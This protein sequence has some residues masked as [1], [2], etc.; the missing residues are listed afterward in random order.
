MLHLDKVTQSLT[1][2][3]ISP[4]VVAEK[5]R[6]LTG[7]QSASQS[8]KFVSSSFWFPLKMVH[9]KSWRMKECTWLAQ[10]G[11]SWNLTKFVDLIHSY[12]WKVFVE[13]GVGYTTW[14]LADLPT[15]QYKLIC[16]LPTKTRRVNLPVQTVLSLTRYKQVY[17]PSSMSKPVNFT[18]HA[19]LSIRQYKQVY[20]YLSISRPANRLVYAG[21]STFQNKQTCQSSSLSGPNKPSKVRLPTNQILA[22]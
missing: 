13:N 2:V 16:L 6:W 19:T 9:K 1:T 14:K 4:A 22:S 17:Q 10:D 12:Y 3:G 20:Q 8:S 21:R 18:A 15:L 5:K 11:I 7:L